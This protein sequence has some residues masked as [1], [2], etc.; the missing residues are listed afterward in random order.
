MLQDREQRQ[1]NS[2]SSFGWLVLIAYAM[3]RP[4]TIVIPSY[5]GFS[6]LEY[7]G[8]IFSYLMLLVLL[9]NINKLVFKGFYLGLLFFCFYCMMSLLWGSTIR[10]VARKILPYIMFFVGTIAVRSSGDIVLILKAMIL[11]YIIPIVGSVFAIIVGIS[12]AL[13][14]RS[15]GVVRYSGL[16]SGQHVLAHMMLFYSFLFAAYKSISGRL[17]RVTG[18]ACYLLLFMSMFCI[19]KTFTR[20]VYLG[21]MVFWL[22]FLWGWSKKLSI[23]FLVLLMAVVSYVYIDGT[24]NKYLWQQREESRSGKSLDDASSGRLT[25]WN[26]NIDIFNKSPLTSK[27]LGTGLGSESKKVMGSS[28]K[29]WSSHN[30][31]LSVLMTLGVLGLAIYI[32]QFIGL[33]FFLAKGIKNIALKYVFFGVVFSVLIMN[34][35]SNSYFS[36]FELSQLLW[37]YMGMMTG[38]CVNSSES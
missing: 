7:F 18:I 24:H 35:V 16:S 38:L 30:D 1:N 27:L 19:Y 10:E 34:G 36:R 12:G 11:G 28:N 14:V 21:F 37:L 15:T 29:A 25:L 13:V 5:A 32:L 33:L 3:L 8:I 4:V 17:S 20:T 6:V 26:H 22:I 2:L 31:Y 23:T 9:L